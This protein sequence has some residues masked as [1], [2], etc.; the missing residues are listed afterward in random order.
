MIIQPRK[1]CFEEPFE[2]VLI[3]GAYKSGTSLLCKTIE[4]YGYNNPRLLSNPDEY[5]HG[6]S[7]GLYLTRECSVVRNW[8]RRLVKA[9]Q[10]ETAWIERQLTGYLVE[11]IG[12]LGP[13]LVL[14]DPYMK[15]TALHWFRAAQILSPYRAKLL[16][17]ERNIHDVSR[18]WA[19]SRFLTWKERTNPEQFRQL[20]A[21]LRPELRMK[22]LA[23]DVETHAVKYQDSTAQFRKFALGLPNGR[24]GR[25]SVVHNLPLLALTCTPC[26]QICH[27][28]A[29]SH[30]AQSAT[31]L[32]RPA[33]R[34]TTGLC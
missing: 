27:H 14:K 18:S 17:T 20:V 22:L 9:G 33:L 1:I 30:T 13:K 31:Q 12:E 8:N 15:M 3:G 19:Y 11:M 24:S 23:L 16:L 34:K 2:L 10:K 5:G 6:I 7:A 4:N 21:P 29:A 25:E 26:C 32:R 28:K